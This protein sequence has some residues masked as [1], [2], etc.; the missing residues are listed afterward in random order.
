VG[1]REILEKYLNSTSKS[2]SVTDIFPRGTK[3][4]LT[5]VLEGIITDKL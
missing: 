3:S 1:D 4:L 5:I 2:T